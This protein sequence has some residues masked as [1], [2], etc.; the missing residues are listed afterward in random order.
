MYK[1]QKK[2]L[3]P[4]NVGR[5][6]A[7]ETAQTHYVLA[8]DIEL[9]PSPKII[10]KFMQMIVERSEPLQSTK[11][12]VFPLHLFEVAA[13]QS[14]PE[15]KTELK[16]MLAKKKAVPFHKKLCPGC[17]T[18][19][20]AKEWQNAAETEGLHVFY[21][22]KRMGP[23]I[24][25]EPIY[26]GTNNEPLYDERLSWEGKSDKMTQVSNGAGIFSDHVSI[27]IISTRHFS[28]GHISFSYLP[29]NFINTWLFVDHLCSIIW[30]FFD[31]VNDTVVDNMSSVQ[32]Q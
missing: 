18:V 4:V 11:P 1:V 17:H 13:D 24:H 31:N 27:F 7:R 2:L 3:Y 23:H 14:I 29:N 25:W 28:V 26:I 30:I 10:P 8:S 15:T 9:Y 16:A 32:F 6:V 21:T 12:K 5:N 20:K 19:P 22:G